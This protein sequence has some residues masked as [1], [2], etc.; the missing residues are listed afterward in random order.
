MERNTYLQKILQCAMLKE[1]GLPG[2]KK[3]V[4]EQLRVV[5][6]GIEYYPFGYSMYG[7]Y[8][9]TWRHTAVLHDI[10]ANAVVSAP[11]N[12]VEEKA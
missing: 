5:Y 11:L 9:G 3:F 12:E 8:D 1:T 2:M 10:K 7:N 6:K 4:P